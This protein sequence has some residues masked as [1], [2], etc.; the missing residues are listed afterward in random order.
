MQSFSVHFWDFQDVS[1]EWR[2]MN[3]MEANCSW[4]SAV[5]AYSFVI[6]S[7]KRDRGMSWM[8]LELLVATWSHSPLLDVKTGSQREKSSVS[9]HCHCETWCVRL[10]HFGASAL[11]KKLFFLII[12][13]HLEMK[14]HRQEN[15]FKEWLTCVCQS[16][17]TYMTPS[18]A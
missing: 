1:L 13:P 7:V 16:Y 12:F 8:R 4:S 6:F 10:T 5:Y 15:T 11:V 9:V 2:E 3:C 14:F 17:W 18:F